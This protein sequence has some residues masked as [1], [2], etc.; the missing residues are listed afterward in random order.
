MN[1]K[2]YP[3]KCLTQRL[4]H[5]KAE[6]THRHA[7][8]WVRSVITMVITTLSHLKYLPIQSQHK[9]EYAYPA[10]IISL[11]P[12]P[13]VFHGTFL[14]RLSTTL[15]TAMHAANIGAIT[16]TTFIVWI[17]IGIK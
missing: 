9:S 10:R 4:S 5:N 15:A 8:W 6:F 17:R 3:R 11:S 2:K 7:T 13:R 1:V 12:P 14:R 16:H